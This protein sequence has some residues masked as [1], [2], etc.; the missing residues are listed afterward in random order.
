MT[1]QGARRAPLNILVVDLRHYRSE[2][3]AYKLPTAVSAP[4]M[5]RMFSNSLLT[6][7]ILTLHGNT[8][9]LMNPEGAFKGCSPERG[10]RP[11][12]PHADASLPC[13]A[14]PVGLFDP[15]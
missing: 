15:G 7:R 11:S 3:L 4:L 5:K 1:A 10:H 12:R 8:D 6:R 2:L 9:D 14:A 13:E